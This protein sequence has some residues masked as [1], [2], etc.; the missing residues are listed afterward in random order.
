M[1]HP[2]MLMWILYQGIASGCKSYLACVKYKNMI[3]EMHEIH[4]SVLWQGAMQTLGVWH[5]KA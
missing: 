2:N 4:I 3:D 5:Y 1:H